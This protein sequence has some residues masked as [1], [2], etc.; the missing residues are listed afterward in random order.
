M[1]RGQLIWSVLYGI[2]L[3]L[4]FP[5]YFLNW[6]WG[7]PGPEYLQAALLVAASAAGGI[8]GLLIEAR[9]KKKAR[10]RKVNP[11]ENQWWLFV[12]ATTGM[13]ERTTK[14]WRRYVLR[15]CPGCPRKLG[16]G[17]KMDC[18]EAQ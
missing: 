10:H 1:T 11:L 8:A 17:H 4:M 13:V 12:S 5:A 16:T 3:L 15:R 2:A 9:P 7:L 18:R 6:S 14:A